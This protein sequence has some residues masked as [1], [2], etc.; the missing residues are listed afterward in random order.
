MRGIGKIGGISLKG[1][2]ENEGVKVREDS[3]KEREH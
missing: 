1:N 2:E 3:R